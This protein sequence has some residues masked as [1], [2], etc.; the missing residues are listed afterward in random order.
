M[1]D[2]DKAGTK[3]REF[4]MKYYPNEE[5]VSEEIASSGKAVKMYEIDIEHM[6]GKQVQER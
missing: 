6:S 1:E 5:L 3:L 4:A 2:A